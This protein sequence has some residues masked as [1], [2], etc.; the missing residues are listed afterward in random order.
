[1]LPTRPRDAD[2]LAAIIAEA[3]RVGTTLEIIGGGSKRAL[4]RPVKASRVLDLSALAGI[5][6]Y[7]PEE[8]VLRAQ[9]GT[10]RA[11]IEQTL[12]A[13]G[14]MLAFEPP[15]LGPLFGH[16]PGL[17]TIGG[18]VAA[19]LS[20]PRR[21]KAGAARDH[22][23]GIA[24]VNGLG[25]RFKSGGRVMKNVTGYDLSKLLT[26]SFGT[27]AAIAELTLKVLPSPETVTTLVLH[28]L[29][30]PQATTAMTAA[31]RSS[32]E[33]SGAAHLPTRASSRAAL[34]T[35][36]A[37]ILRL[38]GFARSVKARAEALA[39][40]LAGFGA[41][42]SVSDGASR[43]LWRQVRDMASL[44]DKDSP[45]WRV[46][47][48]PTCGHRLAAAVGPDDVFYDWGGG[49]VWL[50]LGGREADAGAARLRAALAPLGGH[51]TLI[52]A[53]AEMRARVPVFE[54]QPLALAALS[55]RVK[56][57]FDPKNV[58][59]PRRIYAET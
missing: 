31:L 8:L 12:S 6:L 58:L 1:M 13:H 24:A 29:G 35:N 55:A 50:A 10:T 4:G 30:D 20:G 59:N 42:E 52:R 33:V 47:T 34:G 44:I 2:E 49:L 14:Q 22:I 11:A 39:A 37:T 18:I 57:S 45:L 21:M 41:A 23:L 16:S 17:D 15:D 53:P 51:A 32:H 3:A 56:R 54:P 5:T 25:E 40:E 38:E 48:A 9:A 46:S 27:L 28:G 36:S 19:N 7:E 43:V 26:G